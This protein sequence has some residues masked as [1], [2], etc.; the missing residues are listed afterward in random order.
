LRA[1]LRMG[2]EAIYRANPIGPF[3]LPRP[4]RVLDPT[5]NSRPAAGADTVK[6]IAPMH[7]EL[8]RGRATEPAPDAA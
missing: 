3:G 7:F 1:A 2:A 8:K 5:T 4:S 6:R